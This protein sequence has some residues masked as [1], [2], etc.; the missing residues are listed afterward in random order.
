MIFC[1]PNPAIRASAER[2]TSAFLPTLRQNARDWADPSMRE[3]RGLVSSLKC[4]LIGLVA[5]MVNLFGAGNRLVCYLSPSR[6]ANNVPDGPPASFFRLFNALVEASGL[7]S[8]ST[9]QPVRTDVPKRLPA[10]LRIEP[11]PRRTSRCSIRS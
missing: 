9:F 11:R 5:P 8:A 7:P 3:H 2:T 10:Q 1:R 4:D 6:W